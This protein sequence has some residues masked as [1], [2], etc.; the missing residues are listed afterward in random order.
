[1]ASDNEMRIP[2]RP[3]IAPSSPTLFLPSRSLLP[4]Q[5]R[6]PRAL[7][8]EAIISH[9]HIR[10]F[11]GLLTSYRQHHRHGLSEIQFQIQRAI[12]HHPRLC[13][14]LTGVFR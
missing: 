3:R 10:N 9:R 14:I 5:G 6:A 12:E 4:C 11:S 13:R 7:Q 1:M 2:T 8:N